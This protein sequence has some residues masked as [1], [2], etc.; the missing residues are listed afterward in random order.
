MSWATENAKLKNINLQSTKSVVVVDSGASARFR[1]MMVDQMPCVARTAAMNRRCVLL[2]RSMYRKV[3]IKELAK[4]QGV[5]VYRYDMRGLTWRQIA[6]MFGNAMSKNVLD[7]VLPRLLF[8]TGT[9]ERRPKD[10]W[11]D[12]EM[13][14]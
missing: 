11:A 5:Q 2:K 9:I 12:G 4:L 1:S 10:R 8:S 3:T 7:R 13:P 14:S 6:G